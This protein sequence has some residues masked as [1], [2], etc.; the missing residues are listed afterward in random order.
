MLEDV[1]GIFL[2]SVDTTKF[3]PIEREWGFG[4]TR[5]DQKAHVTPN[6]L[7]H[8]MQNHHPIKRHE[9]AVRT[10]Q[11]GP[12]LAWNVLQPFGLNTP[13]VVMQKREEP[14]PPGLNVAGVH[15][16]VVAGQTP[17]QPVL[18]LTGLTMQKVLKHFGTRPFGYE[19]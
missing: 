2:T 1:I 15:T 6:L 19:L 11:N 16:E 4:K 9:A 8:Q 13:V 5:M 7:C 12:P 10:C 18:P 3:P 14:A 17:C